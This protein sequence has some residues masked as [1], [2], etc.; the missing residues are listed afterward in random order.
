MYKYNLLAFSLLLLLSSCARGEEIYIYDGSDKPDNS[1]E[2]IDVSSLVKTKVFEAGDDNIN[3]YRIPALISTKAGTLLLFCEARKYSW[4][5]HKNTAIVVKRSTDSGKTWSAMDIVASDNYI[6]AYSCPTPVVD[7]ETG[8]IFVLMN[9][10]QPNSSDPTMNTAWLVSSTDDGLT[11][12]EPQ[13]VS[14]TMVASGYALQGVGVGC[15]IQMKGGNYEGRMIIP[16]RQIDRKTK[17]IFNRTVY[18]D[19]HGETWKVG[20]CASKNGEH[21]IAESPLGILVMNSRSGD[22]RLI[23]KST[24]GGNSWSNMEAHPTLRSVIDGCQASILAKDSVMLFTSPKGGSYSDGSVKVDDRCNFTIYRSLDTG[25]TWKTEQLLYQNASGY[26]SLTSLPDGR[27]CVA[28]EAGDH[29]GF[30]KEMGNRPTGWSRIDVI[31]MPKEVMDP[32]CW[33]GN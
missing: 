23:A 22:K 25:I 31:V 7:Y 27:I 16:T 14:A 19:D 5:D 3:T 2:L 1:F 15:G 10:W 9:Y 26:S 18:S 30:V 24:D 33:F 12:S 6:G 32:N 29:Y 8:K 20:E 28:F 21:E 13:N 4:R 17:K 11:W